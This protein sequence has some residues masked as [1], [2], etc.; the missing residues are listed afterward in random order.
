MFNTCS[1][2][3]SDACEVGDEYSDE[4]KVLE[5]VVRRMEEFLTITE[6]NEDGE[7]NEDGE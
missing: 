1:G 4:V 5:K 3:K 2:L 6:K 7:V